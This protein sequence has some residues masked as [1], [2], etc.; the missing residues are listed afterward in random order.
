[1]N[2]CVL[3]AEI[4]QEPQLRYTADN[5]GVT[6]MLVQFPNSQ[7]L[8]DP[9]ATL[10]VVG[11]GNLATEIQQNY[12]QGDRVILVGRLSMNTVDRPE[13]FKEK[14]AELTVQQIQPVGG[15]FDTD[16]LSS[17]S[18]TP[19]FTETTPRQPSSPPVS[20]PGKDAP[21]YDSPR[22]AATPVTTNV[23]VIPQVTNPE[24]I[25][26]PTY[27]RTTYAPVKQEE[28]DPDDI[29]F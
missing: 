6:E 13:G 16:P 22:P 7:R 15:S 17:A 29:P 23:G 1:M 4:I 25:P 24:P 20:S 5:L 27:E 3:L 10:K 12:H 9:P 11:W 14:R 21:S 8:E 26:Q 28:P 18:I 2:S 19:S